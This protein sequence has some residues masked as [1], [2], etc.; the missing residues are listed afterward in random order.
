MT[1]NIRKSSGEKQR[2]DLHKFRRSLFKAGATQKTVD[3]IVRSLKK[4][5]PSSTKQIHEIATELLK[6]QAHPLLR[7]AIT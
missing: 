2:F 6:K 1:Y 4:E 3:S 7:I 5:K